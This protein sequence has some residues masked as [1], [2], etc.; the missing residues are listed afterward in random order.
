[1]KDLNYLIAAASNPIDVAKLCCSAVVRVHYKNK[2]P[3]CV[4]PFCPLPRRVSSQ[5]I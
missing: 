1:L 5:S 2:T 3:R 4:S